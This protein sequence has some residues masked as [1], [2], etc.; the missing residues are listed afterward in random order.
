MFRIPRLYHSGHV[1]PQH[2]NFFKKW[3]GFCIDKDSPVGR[4]GSLCE[5]KRVCARQESM[6]G[7]SEARGSLYAAG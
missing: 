2:C 4:A 3:Q 5:R 6:K 7:G 1:S